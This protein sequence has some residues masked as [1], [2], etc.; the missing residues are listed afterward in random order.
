VE[1]L[2]RCFRGRRDEP[3]EDLEIKRHYQD[4]S[5]GCTCRGACAT[6]TA[7]SPG[8]RLTSPP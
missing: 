4:H 8:P 2:A 5:V 6:C 7:V 1:R 3:W